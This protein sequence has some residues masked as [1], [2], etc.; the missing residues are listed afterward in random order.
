[1]VRRWPAS[2]ALAMDLSSRTSPT[3]Q[4]L[5][6]GSVLI[7]S[8]GPRSKVREL[9]VGPEKAAVSKLGVCQ[10]NM[11]VDTT[12]SRNPSSLAVVIPIFCLAASS[13]NIVSLISSK[14]ILS[15]RSAI[16]T[17][18]AVQDVPDPDKPET[19]RFQ[20]VTSWIGHRDPAMTDADRLK[21]PRSKAES[22]VDPFKSAVLWIPE[23]TP[24]VR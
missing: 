11:A 1:M 17:V 4:V 24:E 13:D 22:L 8:D 15:P 16:L 5:P 3:A 21:L 9:L 6:S 12:A 20:V 18:R 19:W 23:G 2:L 14:R 7:R 10:T